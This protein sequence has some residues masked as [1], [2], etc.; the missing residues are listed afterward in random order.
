MDRHG[1]SQSVTAEKRSYDGVRVSPQGDRLATSIEGNIWS[2]ETDRG[3][4]TRI[5]FETSTDRPPIWSHDGRRLIFSSFKP[6]AAD[7]YWRDAEGQGRD[8]QLLVS[9][10][11]DLVSSCSSDGKTLAFDRLLPSTRWDVWVMPLDGKREPSP[12]TNTAFVE[13]DG[14]LSP[15]SRWIAY[16]SNESGRMEVYLQAHPGPGERQQISNEGGRMPRWSKKGTELLY[17]SG[18]K[19]MSVEV[20]PDPQLRV[21]K[22][23]ILFERKHQPLSYDVTP[24]GQRFVMVESEQESAPTQLNVILNWHQ[25][26]KRLVP[27]N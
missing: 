17:F 6:T 12:I 25:E 8:E 10:Y 4:L 11:D 7:I 18:P 22:P 21:T 2:F 27:T 15:D 24:D 23:R 19:M 20:Q 3:T 1:S 9:E 16:V 14:Q 26:L 13:M 5:T